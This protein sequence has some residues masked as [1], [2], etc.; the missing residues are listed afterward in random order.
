VTHN[1]FTVVFVSTANIFESISVFLRK[2]TCPRL[3][4][5][6]QDRDDERLIIKGVAAFDEPERGRKCPVYLRGAVYFLDVAIKLSYIC[7]DLQIGMNSGE[8][9]K[10]GW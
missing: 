8:T 2:R 5:S 10:R 4:Q 9:D 3:L 1:H 6:G 7:T